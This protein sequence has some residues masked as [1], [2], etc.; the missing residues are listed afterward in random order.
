MH[1]SPRAFSSTIPADP[2][3]PRT[4][5]SERARE[6]V[7]STVSRYLSGRRRPREREKEKKKKKRSGREGRI[8]GWEHAA[9]AEKEDEQKL[10]S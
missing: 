9:K 4:R 6:R 3:Y 10:K 1:R 5:E 2:N 8:P 7:R